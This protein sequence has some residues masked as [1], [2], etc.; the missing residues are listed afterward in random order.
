M[1]NIPRRRFLC[2]VGTLAL[3]RDAWA[4]RLV[5]IYKIGVLAHYVSRERFARVQE[6]LRQRGYIEGRNLVIEYRHTEGRTERLPAL[7]ADLVARGVDVILAMAN[8]EVIAAKRATTKIPIVM[9]YSL[10]PI[11]M[12]FVASLARPGGNV[13]GTT[14][15]APETS[16]KLFEIL[17]EVLP[18]ARRV[19]VLWEES[20]PGMDQY[21]QAGEQALANLGMTWTPYPVR[22]VGDLDDIFAKIRRSR[23]DALYVV[24]TGAAFVHR[25]RIINFAADERLPAMYTAVFVTH[26]GGLIAYAPDTDALA[27]RCAHFIDRILMGEIPANLPVEQ[28]AKYRLAINNRAAKAL[29]LVIPRSILVRADEIID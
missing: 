27:D 21:R 12:G 10:A 15:Q 29:R 17:R 11:E 6:A 9:L 2:G 5:R 8:E 18:S 16:G 20:F 7:A 13:T 28:P 22:A 24:P 14:L 23:P 3:F 26:E 19:A 25:A 1:S 4:Q